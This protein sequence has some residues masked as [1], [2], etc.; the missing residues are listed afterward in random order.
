[1]L[2]DMFIN[3]FIVYF[4][5]FIFH[6]SNSYYISHTTG[7]VHKY[8]HTILFIIHLSHFKLF[9]TF[10]TLYYISHTKGHVHKYVHTI[11]FNIHI[12]HF[13][14]F[15]TFLILQDMFI[16]MFILY[17]STF[18]FHISNSLLHFSYYWTCS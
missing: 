3:M 17:F 1:M 18:I 11:L 13:K 5:T 12:S 4:S 15:I 7:H 6:I 10:Q 16:N 14:L 8:V 9:I 2:L